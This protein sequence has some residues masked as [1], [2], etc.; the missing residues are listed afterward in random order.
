MQNISSM[1]GT[2]TIIW[3]KLISLFKAIAE[4]YN[5]NC[6]IKLGQNITYYLKKSF[7]LSYKNITLL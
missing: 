4:M 1:S 2:T 5:N 7:L 6:I 3:F